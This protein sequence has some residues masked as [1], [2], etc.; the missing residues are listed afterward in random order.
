MQ[1]TKDVEE[2][3]EPNTEDKSLSAEEKKGDEINLGK[4]GGLSLGLT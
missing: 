1:A 4:E 3:K 2:E